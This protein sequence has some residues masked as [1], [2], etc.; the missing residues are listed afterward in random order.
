MNVL[1]RVREVRGRAPQV[2]DLVCA[3]VL[4]FVIAAIW[5]AGR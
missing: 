5:M 4:G 3:V 2:F 1:E